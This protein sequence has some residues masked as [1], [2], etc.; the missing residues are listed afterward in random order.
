MLFLKALVNEKVYLDGLT[1]RKNNK[2]LKLL[3]EWITLIKSCHT[4]KIKD[5]I[6]VFYS[7][8]V[9]IGSFDC[10]FP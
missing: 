5:Q 1:A 6:N 2:K 3:L 7:P 4:L 10:R 9:G 8:I